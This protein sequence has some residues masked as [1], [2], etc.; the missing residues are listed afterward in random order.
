MSFEAWAPSL[1]SA[2]VLHSFH[3]F[4]LLEK[5]HGYQIATTNSLIDIYKVIPTLAN[6]SVLQVGEMGV[7]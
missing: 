4:K 7:C 6:F 3:S 2:M 5:L 1:F